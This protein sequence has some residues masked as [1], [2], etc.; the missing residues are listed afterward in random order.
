MN[1]K[2]MISSTI[3]LIIFGLSFISCNGKNESTAKETT[4]AA[5]DKLMVLPIGSDPTIINPLYAND[6]VSLT[7]S[8]V[9]YDPLY[10]I[11]NGEILYD[12]L[13]EKL[14]NSS[15]FLTYTLKLRQDVT[16]H[17]GKPFTAD[18][19][20]Y[21]LSVIMDE[22]QNAKGRSALIFGDKVIE[23]KKLDDYTVEFKLPQVNMS[24]VQNLS[25][26]KPIPKHIYMGQANIAESKNNANPIGNGSFKF[27][28]QR[29][30]ETYQVERNN[31]YY[32]DKALLDGIVYRVIPNSNAVMVA[33]ENGEINAAY[34]KANQIEKYKKNENLQIVTFSEGMVNNIFFRVSNPK[35]N[36]IR[37]RQAISYAI[38][39][40]K[41]LKG[42]YGGPEYA[43][44][45]SSPFAQETQYY[46]DDV[47]KYQ[48][49]IDK[50]KELLKE[51]KID[52]LSLRLM[53]TSG[54]PAQEK[55]AL[56]IQEM[57][58]KI[59]ITIELL[60]LERGS[61]I[62]KLLNVKNQDFEMALNGY[63][64]GD[65]PDSYGSLFTK[66]SPENFSGYLNPEI[67]K[68]FAA[69]VTET[70][71]SKREKMYKEIQQILVKDAVQISTAYIKS[72]VV[73]NKQFKNLKEANPAPIHMFDY[74]NKIS[75][76]E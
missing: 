64:F 1:K 50:A 48:Y 35:V 71:S 72:I 66:N 3:L 14:E 69:A 67:D 21:T 10:N 27:K 55:E 62:E 68:L 13:A 28:E 75:K 25:S 12:G 8:H 31:N 2:L 32:G 63:V 52:S 45:A 7:I 54:N 43:A 41:L 15:D 59:N 22:K 34:I 49:N 18:D 38:D 26:I 58:K 23:Y 29:T 70:D 19:L 16:W 74:F 33:L 5:T 46:T 17:D 20:V 51:A 40:D 56:L 4:K 9:I 39:K 36:D 30:G 76:N 73:V 37:L 47:E 61:F 24:F 60:P 57:L 42:A 6:R 44:I 65:N 11:K 53:Y